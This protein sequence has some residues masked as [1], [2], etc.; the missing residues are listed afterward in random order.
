MRMGE[1]QI[2]LRALTEGRPAHS[3][4]QRRAVLDEL[5]EKLR[6]T[7]QNTTPWQPDTSDPFSFSATII[8]AHVD[9]SEH[10][11][12]RGKLDSGCDENWI[13]MEVL[14]RARLEDQVEA[15]EDQRIYIAFDGG[16]FE[17]MGKVDVTWY[18]VNAGKSRKTSFFVHDQVPFDMVLGRVFIKE[19]SIFMFNEPALALRQGKFKKGNNK[20]QWRDAFANPS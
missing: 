12:A 14:T 11:V 7:T 8:R 6:S 2:I 10:T 18:A 13:S 16:E 15:M 9:K 3:D 5:V 19:E 17:P 4:E 1:I 20:L